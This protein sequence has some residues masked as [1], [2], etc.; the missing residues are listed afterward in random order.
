MERCVVGAG[1]RELSPLLQT[2]L[3]EPDDE[4]VTLTWTATLAVA[5]PYP[6]EMTRTMLSAPSGLALRYWRSSPPYDLPPA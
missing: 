1:S 4:R 5:A 3:I 6:E 2:V